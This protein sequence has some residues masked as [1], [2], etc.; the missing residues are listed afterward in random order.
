MLEENISWSQ[1][2]HTIFL[3]EMKKLMD[4]RLFLDD[5]FVC[6]PTR[7]GSSH[8]RPGEASEWVEEDIVYNSA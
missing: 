1:F 7:R 8:P 3:M 5:F 4:C 2:Y 6:F